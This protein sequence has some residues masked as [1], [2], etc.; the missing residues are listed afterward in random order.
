MADDY[1]GYQEFTGTSEE[2]N[3][4]LENIDYSTWYVNEYLILH[5]TDDGKTTEQLNRQ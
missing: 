4:Y 1:K 3:N 5:N 2:I